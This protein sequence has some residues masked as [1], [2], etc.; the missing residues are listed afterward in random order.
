MVDKS[1]PLSFDLL[2][3]NV[4]NENDDEVN[5]KQED[6]V[7]GVSISIFLEDLVPALEFQVL[8]II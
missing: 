6:H 2:S 1:F 8:L 4:D 3:L 5:E 7:K